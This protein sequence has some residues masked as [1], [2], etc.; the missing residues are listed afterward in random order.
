MPE[1]RGQTLL[2]K[3]KLNS[4]NTGRGINR[5]HQLKVETE[6]ADGSGLTS[7]TLGVHQITF[8]RDPEGNPLPRS[9]DVI[10]VDGSGLTS[11]TLGFHSTH[12]FSPTGME[13]TNGSGLTS[14]TLGI[15]GQPVMLDPNAPSNPALAG[16]AI[17][18][19]ADDGGWRGDTG[20]EAGSDLVASGV[21]ALGGE[22]SMGSS[23]DAGSASV[24]QAGGADSGDDG[25][26]DG[27]SDGKSSR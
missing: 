4:V 8:G 10:G 19:Q 1:R 17:A 9:I 12:L 11:S 15:G 22:D 2:L 7:S 16:T 27:K 13:M 24:E 20:A 18:Q 5:E 25:K 14:S 3:G 23:D 6:A 26:T 21:V